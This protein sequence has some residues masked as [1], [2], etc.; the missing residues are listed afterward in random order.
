MEIQP[1]VSVKHYQNLYPCQLHFINTYI[2]SPFFD[3][4]IT[5]SL[6]S[7]VWYKCSNECTR[8]CFSA[9]FFQVTFRDFYVTLASREAFFTFM[10]IHIFDINITWK[11]ALDI[12]FLFPAT[13]IAVL[14]HVRFSLIWFLSV[15]FCYT[16]SHANTSFN[17][18]LT[19]RSLVS[20]V[21]YII[22]NSLTYKVT[23]M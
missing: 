1:S 23:H 5:K 18:V 3:E 13:N 12:T 10:S 14:E 11:S 9:D 7:D 19:F 8:E 2:Q 15:F 4:T 22:I 21:N 6:N 16:I 20:H 17:D